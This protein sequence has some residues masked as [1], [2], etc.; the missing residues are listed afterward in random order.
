MGK[1]EQKKDRWADLK[2]SA[3]TGNPELGSCTDFFDA[4]SADT[5]FLYSLTFNIL[6]VNH[7]VVSWR[8]K[9]SMSFPVFSQGNGVTHFI[10]K[11]SQSNFHLDVS[12]NAFKCR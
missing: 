2:V 12:E 3:Q 9:K 8:R 1:I 6:I 4:L 5:W 7:A 11:L 10:F